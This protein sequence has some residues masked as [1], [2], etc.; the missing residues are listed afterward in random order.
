MR[1]PN[2]TQEV[3]ATETRRGGE[4]REERIFDLVS[5][6]KRAVRLLITRLYSR[7]EQSCAVQR[8]ALHT[9]SLRK[10]IYRRGFTRL[11]PR[12]IFFFFF[13]SHF[14]VAGVLLSLQET[15]VFSAVFQYWE[16]IGIAT[17]EAFSN[18]RNRPK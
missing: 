10:A 3:R 18:T 4:K 12:V 17:L 13:L 8:G 16:S 1:L 7:S 5:T 9:S 2:Q 11:A 6:W 14:F 15:N